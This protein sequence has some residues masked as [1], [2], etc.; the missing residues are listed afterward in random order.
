MRCA[1]AAEAWDV[2]F[3]RMARAHVLSSFSSSHRLRHD[4]RS[5]THNMYREYRDLSLAA[6]V[7]TMC[8]SCGVG[9]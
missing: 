9:D 4:S 1:R 8:T 7:T 2:L 5:G 6:A 3:R